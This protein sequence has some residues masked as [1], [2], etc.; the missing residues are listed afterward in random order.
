MKSNYQ[1][2]LDLLERSRF[3]DTIEEAALLVAQAQVYATL[4]TL[5]R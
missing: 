4:A 3:A 5:D 1:Y 2:A